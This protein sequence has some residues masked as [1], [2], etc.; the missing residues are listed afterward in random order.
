MFRPFVFIT[1]IHVY[2]IMEIILLLKIKVFWVL[3]LFLGLLVSCA[4]L[5]LKMK[6]V[7]SGNSHSTTRRSI[8]EYFIFHEHRCENL[9]SGI[10]LLLQA[11][12]YMS[13]SS[14]L[15]VYSLRAQSIRISLVSEAAA[16]QHLFVR[17]EA[18][19]S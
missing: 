16:S 6:A 17:R 10:C 5:T 4:S 19:A 8:P 1:P 13:S 12:V 11:L 3:M 7:R 2:K 15:M 18:V 9:K 14:S